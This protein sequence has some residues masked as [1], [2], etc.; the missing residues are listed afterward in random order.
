VFDK[1]YKWLDGSLTAEQNLLV[2]LLAD[3]LGAE[4]YKH[5]RV[6]QKAG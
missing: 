1:G 6:Y 5:Y 4:R 3:R 2:N